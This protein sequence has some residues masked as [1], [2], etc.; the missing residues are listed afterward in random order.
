LKRDLRN[1]FEVDLKRDPSDGL[2]EKEAFVKIH[3]LMYKFKK[4]GHDMI[5]DANN[6]ERLSLLAKIEQIKKESD[7]V[8][9][10]ARSGELP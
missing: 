7:H 5:I 3:V 2:F 10:K 9:A 4:F 8:E 1:N 6:R